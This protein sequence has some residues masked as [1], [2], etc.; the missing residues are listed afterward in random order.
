MDTPAVW[1]EGATVAQ[2][3]LV[4]AERYAR[5]IK[6]LDAVSA[7]WPEVGSGLTD[8]QMGA[9]LNVRFLLAQLEG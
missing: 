6:V 8:E 5:I 2:P 9:I 3:V 1:I 4:P 7:A